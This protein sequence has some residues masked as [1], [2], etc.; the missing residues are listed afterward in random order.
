FRGYYK[1]QLI[2]GIAPNVIGKDRFAVSIFEGFSIAIN[3]IPCRVGLGLSPALYGDVYSQCI[4]FAEP[5]D[6]P[7]DRDQEVDFTFDTFQG[8]HGTENGV[9]CLGADDKVIGPHQ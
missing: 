6:W 4:D 5:Y 1:T 8:N 9:L 3:R 2:Q 7:S